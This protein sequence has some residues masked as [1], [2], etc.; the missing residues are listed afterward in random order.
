MRRA[1]CDMRHAITTCDMRHAACDMR[2][3]TCNMLLK[4]DRALAT[5]PKR[6][7]VH[8][9][10]TNT[11]STFV[12]LV[13]ALTHVDTRAHAHARAHRYHSIQK[14]IDTT[15]NIQ[16]ERTFG[17]HG[18]L[19]VDMSNVYMACHMSTCPQHVCQAC[20]M[21]TCPTC[22]SHVN[23]STCLHGIRCQHVQ[24]VDT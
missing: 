5:H 16:H 23:M 21:S 22:L 12:S 9:P 2:H 18:L 3:A 24:P 14:L 20:H 17:R 13:H 19:H 11:L 4:P 1:A 8:P 7:C 15:C 6:E 10:S